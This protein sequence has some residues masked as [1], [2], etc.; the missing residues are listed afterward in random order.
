MNNQLI[1][2][3]LKSTR[4]KAYR[5]W[6]IASRYHTRGNHQR[7]ERYRDLGDLCMQVC[8]QFGEAA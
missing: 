8:K 4:A 2:H 3:R 7:Y 1:T 6:W 5:L